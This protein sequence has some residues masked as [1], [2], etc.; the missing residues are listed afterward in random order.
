[1][2]KGAKQPFWGWLMLVE[3]SPRSTA[4]VKCDEPHFAVFPEFQ[5]ASYAE[6]YDLLCQKLVKERMYDSAC[7]LMSS[8]TDVDTG[9]Y[10]CLSDVTS[11]KTFVSEF[12]GHI[13]STAAQ[14][15]SAVR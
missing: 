1:M 4:P 3:E 15:D 14:L 13:A 8:K 11:L 12:A 2:G 9:E 5:G 7:L 10:R 6:R